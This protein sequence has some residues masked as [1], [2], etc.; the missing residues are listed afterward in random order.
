MNL[1][2]ES[3]SNNLEG[4]GKKELWKVRNERSDGYGIRIREKAFLTELIKN[5]GR[6][7]PAYEAAFPDEAGRVSD[8]TKLTRG[9]GI[10][11]RGRVQEYMQ[12][13][14]ASKEI[15]PEWVIG[16]IAGI[17]K[18]KDTERTSDKLKAL[19]LLGKFLKL[20]KSDEVGTKNTI[21]LNISENTA[22]RIFERRKR[23]ETGGRGEFI[24][25]GGESGATVNGEENAD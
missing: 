18:D 7:V 14:L 4:L 5:D 1:S 13:V 12:T 21:N 17:A 6:I 2:I 8:V 11:S 24:D 9:K 19:E 25:I 10:L 15:S 16:E 20:F 3:A 23:Y 22:R